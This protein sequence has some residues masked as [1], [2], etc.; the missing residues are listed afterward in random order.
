MAIVPVGELILQVPTS[1]EPS[2]G[3]ELCAA[4]RQPVQTVIQCCLDIV[5]GAEVDRFS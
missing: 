1:D 4:L 5:L 2:Y 3:T